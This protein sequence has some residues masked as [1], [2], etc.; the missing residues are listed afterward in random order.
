MPFL[1]RASS[2]ALIISFSADQISFNL[3]VN[4]TALPTACFISGVKCGTLFFIYNIK[5]AH[6]IGG[7]TFRERGNL[8]GHLQPESWAASSA[9]VQ[10]PTKQSSFF[11]QLSHWEN[12]TQETK[13]DHRNQRSSPWHP[14]RVQEEARL[15]TPA[16]SCSLEYHRK[17]DCMNGRRHTAAI[18]LDIQQSFDRV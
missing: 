14:R 2:N 6:K 16:P 1:T 7:F 11:S 4:K 15:R 3:T 10:L 18:F 8:R 13:G 12:L 5:Y 17:H 9:F